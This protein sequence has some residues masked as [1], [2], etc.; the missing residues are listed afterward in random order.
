MMVVA[1]AVVEG[2]WGHVIVA[3]VITWLVLGGYAL[4]LWIRSRNLEE[5]EQ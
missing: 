4:S 3:Y 1:T 5:G 2:W